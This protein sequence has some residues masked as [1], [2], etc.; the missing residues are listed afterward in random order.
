[1]PRN[2]WAAWAQGADITTF[3]SPDLCAYLYN[4]CEALIGMANPSL[5]DEV[6]DTLS[7]ALQAYEAVRRP[8][9]AKVQ[10]MARRGETTFHLTD[11][12]DV[13]RRNQSLRAAQ[14][15]GTGASPTGWLYGYDAYSVDLD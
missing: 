5:A 14:A 7:S 11:W 15:K 10:E 2:C 13:W 3:E 6:T 9:T 4:E 12:R 8:H 1:M